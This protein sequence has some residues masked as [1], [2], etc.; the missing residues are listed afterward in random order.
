MVILEWHYNFLIFGKSIRR[1]EKEGLFAC[2]YETKQER[3]RQRER[4]EGNC[5]AAMEFIVRFFKHCCKCT[6]LPACECVCACVCEC[7][8]VC[9]CVCVCENV[10][11]NVCVNE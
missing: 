8:C 9:V 6:A 11:V 2:V 10:N 4:Q 7:V 5:K 3:L 1:N